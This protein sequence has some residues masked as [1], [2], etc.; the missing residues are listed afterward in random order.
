MNLSF[1]KEKIKIL[2][3]EDI[4]KSAENFL[5]KNG[6]TN[7]KCLSTALDENELKK[8]VSSVHFIGIRSR[9]QLSREILEEADN[10]LGIACFCIGTNQVDLVA[11]QAKGICVFNA[12]HSNTRSVA[13]LVIAESIMLMRDIIEKNKAAHKGKWMKTAEK[14][15]EVR[16]KNIGIIGYGHIGSQVSILA[17]AMG[18]Q[19][20]Y[21]DIEAKLPMGNARQLDTLKEVLSISDII[22]VHVPASADTV[23]LINRENIKHFKAESVLINASR[24]NV[25]EIPAL[26]E[27]LQ[28]GHIKGAALDVFPK[29]PASK[30][31]EFVSDLQGMENVILTPHIGGST[32]EAQLN[33]GIEVAN[34]IV[35]YSDNGSTTGAVNFPTTALPIQKGNHHRLLHVHKNIP[36]IMSKINQIIADKKI[37]ILGQS[38]QTKEELGYVVIDVESS[39]GQSLY[40]DMVKIKGTIK[41]RLLF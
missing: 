29:E 15:Y 26:V 6:Y 17:E 38:L 21:F 1:P 39:F 2:L 13:E 3:L 25:I 34:K 9:T 37:N 41:C 4:H 31:E 22:T 18:M 28:S 23:D 35:Q 30:E 40:N 5:K 32:I 16:N 10:L 11:A 33:I 27:A 12:P 20:Y 19:V 24:G 8:A 7:I 36:G 14:S